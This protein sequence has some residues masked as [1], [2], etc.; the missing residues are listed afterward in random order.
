MCIRDRDQI[1]VE[2]PWC[3]DD[4][5]C[6]NNTDRRCNRILIESEIMMKLIQNIDVYA[7]QHL[8]TKDVLVINDKIVK[9]ADAGTILA[10]GFLAD[11]EVIDGSNPVSYTHLLSKFFTSCPSFLCCRMVVILVFIRSPPNCIFG[12]LIHNDEFIFRRTSCVDTVSYTHLQVMC[13]LIW[14]R[15]M[16][17]RF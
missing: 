8:G 9:I 13:H 15:L 17:E 11:A 3:T 12:V 2:I 5:C 6:Y 14:G 4:W 16:H 1:H 7:P 10:E